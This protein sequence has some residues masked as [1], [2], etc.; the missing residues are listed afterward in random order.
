[1]SLSVVIAAASV[2]GLAGPVYGQLEWAPNSVVGPQ[3]P[4]HRQWPSPSSAAVTCGQ[5][6]R[7]HSL[8]H[9]ALSTE[10]AEALRSYNSHH[11][12]KFVCRD[13][14]T[15]QTIL[16]ITITNTHNNNL[17]GQTQTPQP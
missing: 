14:A 6:D 15:L 10:T 16:I 5:T 3:L 7:R 11:Y 4:Y 9:H 12:I 13:L 1:M 2:S 8:R 17:L